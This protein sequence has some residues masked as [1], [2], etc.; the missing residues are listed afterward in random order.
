MKYFKLQ[1]SSILMRIH[2][3]LGYQLYS[4]FLLLNIYITNTPVFQARW[5]K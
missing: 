4:K 2:Y 3:A 5:Y 1:F